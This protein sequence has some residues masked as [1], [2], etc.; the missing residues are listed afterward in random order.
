MRRQ[1]ERVCDTHPDRW[2]CPDCLVTYSPR[3][4]TYGLIIHDGGTSAVRI[5][6]CPWCGVALPSGERPA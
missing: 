1:L 5:H 2:S 3:S 4:H 6:F